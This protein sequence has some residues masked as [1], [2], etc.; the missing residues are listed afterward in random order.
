M[1]DKS[2]SKLAAC[3]LI[4]IALEA[5]AQSA[6]NGAPLQYSATLFAQGNPRALAMD[7]RLQYRH[8][9]GAGS[10]I[11]GFSLI[12]AGPAWLPPRGGNE[13]PPFSN[14]SLCVEYF[15]PD[16]FLALRRGQSQS[17]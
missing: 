14:L 4:L 15:T 13:N 5:Q 9:L 8:D 6:P 3:V 1:L 16:Y 10:A 11:G 12:A 17:S 2:A 7:L